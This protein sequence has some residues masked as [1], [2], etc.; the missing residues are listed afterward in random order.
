VLLL[1]RALF[2]QLFLLATYGTTKVYKL[3]ERKSKNWM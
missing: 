1:A 2:E 3:I